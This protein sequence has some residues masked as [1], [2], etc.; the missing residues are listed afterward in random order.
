LN[1]FN[2]TSSQ[3][4]D[5]RDIVNVI[6]SLSVFAMSSSDLNVILVS[7]GLEGVFLLSELGELDV[8]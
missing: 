3:S 4:S 6:I 2:F 1:K 5:V 8:D 7:D